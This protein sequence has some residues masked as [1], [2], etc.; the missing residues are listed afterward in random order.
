ME[1]QYGIKIGDE[2]LNKNSELVQR[3]VNYEQ[4]MMFRMSNLVE[5]DKYYFEVE[6]QYRVLDEGSAIDFR[7]LKMILLKFIISLSKVGM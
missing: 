2:L 1:R 4:A 6:N 5:E 7:K 3:I